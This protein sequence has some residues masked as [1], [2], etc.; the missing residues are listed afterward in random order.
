MLT[1]HINKNATGLVR[2]FSE[3]LSKDDYFFSG[4]SI[5][6]RYGGK[7]KHELE[8][9]DKVSQK[10]FSAL[11]HNKHPKTGEKLTA[12]NA[13]ERRTSIEYT[14]SAPKSVSIMM[15]LSDKEKGKEIL[16]AHR[17]SVKKAMQ[18]IEKSM[19]TQTRINGRKTYVDAN[20]IIYARFEHFTSRPTKEDSSLAKYS[21]DMNLHSHAICMSI[22]KYKNRYQAIEGST[23][24]K[25]AS[26]YEA[27]YHSHL[28]KSLKDLGYE[29]ERTKDR[30]EIKSPGLTRRTIEKF[31]RRTA[32]IEKLAK[33]LGV[34]DAKKKG[35]LGARSRINKSKVKDNVDL[36]KIWLSRLTQTEL[37]AIRNAKSAHQKSP[38]PMTAKRA[39][40]RAL[41]HHL[42]RNST[43]PVKKLLGHALT[44]GY[45]TLTLDT[46]RQELKSRSNI[47]Y[48]K[49]GHLNYLTTKEMVRGE[50]RMIEFASRS[51]GTMPPINAGYKIQ[52]EFLN[53]EQRGAVH[54]ILKS[55]D[56]VSILLGSAGVGKTTLLIEVKEAAEQKGKTIIALA[57]SSQASRD[58][59]RENEFQS[60]DTIATFLKSK[61]LQKQA[62]GNIILVDEASLVGVKTMNQI[63]D[64]AHKMSSRV[65]L[66]GDVKQHGSIEHGS[67]L[68]Q[69]KE[70][71]NLKVASVN[72]ILRQRNNPAYK[73]AIECLAD[74]RTRIGFDKLDKLKAVIEI[75]DKDERHRAIAKNY[76]QSLEHKRSALVV[77]PTHEEGRLI[78]EAIRKE[79]KARERIS[80]I[81]RSFIIQKNR[82]LTQAQKQDYA[83]YEQGM[84]LQFHQNYKGGYK[85]GKIYNVVSKNETGKVF[86]Q[87]AE[88]KKPLP[89]PK[90]AYERFQVFDKSNITLST[91]DLIRIT[92]NGR[93]LEKN[94]LHNGQSYIVKGFTSEGDIKL[95]NGKTLSK[96]YANF[97]HNYVNTS[98]A[99]QGATCKDVY[100]AQSSMSF[101]ATNEKTF[102][103]GA[104]R[105]TDTIKIFTDDKDAL[106]EA[107]SKSGEQ[108]SARD[109]ANAQ[110]K[111]RRKFKR[112]RYYNHLNNYT[113]NDRPK[114]QAKI[115]LQE[116]IRDKT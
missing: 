8:L 17:F 6:G 54:H 92:Q 12:R 30:W 11:A 104:S 73:K 23:I 56:R 64:T 24:H 21:A 27:I 39:I 96:A 115:K 58:V 99:A 10:T 78:T 45:G 20:G 36:K 43:V 47:L 98:Y 51:K 72:T 48:A 111:R 102:Y 75:E 32:E 13:A 112:Q 35:E 46:V 60:A 68:K 69:I 109:I 3:S 62:K 87:S 5:P 50:D 15:A 22:C 42:E 103:V 4:Q 29:I 28:S 86:I 40:D 65:L 63:F 105:A 44:L 76:V 81:E 49:K 106:R 89:L 107:V 101:S 33:K 66:V 88:D 91:G 113:K 9:P 85:A 82:F 59:L 100:V 16:N 74:G 52:R 1:I 108:M 37:H 25:V 93:T 41:A 80:G 83:Q 19:K 57:N 53:K 77:S 114:E 38:D 67:A 70:K 95:S 26:F 71:S 116:P 34:K 79:M 18:E 14:F 55:N 84:R 2:Y 97:T 31:S 7:L 61:D 110:V 90:D 94:R